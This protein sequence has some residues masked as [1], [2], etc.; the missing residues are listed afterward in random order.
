MNRFLQ[1]LP[2]QGRGHAAAASAVFHE[3]A[4]GEFVS[5][6]VLGLTYALPWVAAAARQATWSSP[7]A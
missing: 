7:W 6:A 4:D 2:R 5:N 1:R 3:H